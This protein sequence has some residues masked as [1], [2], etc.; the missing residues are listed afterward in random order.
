MSVLSSVP[1]V[2]VASHWKVRDVS[3]GFLGGFAGLRTTLRLLG[4]KGGRATFPEKIGNSALII[5]AM[6]G[7]IR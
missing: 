6:L 7:M 2:K 1:H 4:G 3:C 5:I